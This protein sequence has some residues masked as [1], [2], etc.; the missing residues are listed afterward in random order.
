M[1]SYICIS[2][3]T[4]RRDLPDIRICTTLEGAQHLRASAEISGK[5][6]P[7]VLKLIYFTLAPPITQSFENGF[8]CE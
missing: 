4:A 8:T 6:Q 7:D 3:N 2:Y 5:Y 1:M